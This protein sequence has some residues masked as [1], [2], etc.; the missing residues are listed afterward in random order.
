MEYLSYHAI[1]K[2]VKS[3]LEK[4][5]RDFQWLGG[6]LDRKSHLVNWDTMCTSKEKGGLGIRSL[7]KL[8]KSLLE[9]WN[10][11]LAVE[12]N[13]PWK[14]IIKL[15]Y[16]LEEGAWFSVEPK[17]SFVGLWKDIKREA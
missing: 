8:N 11:R 15:K 12:D 4:I 3:R 6:N 17:G 10:L 5:Q 9:K 13:P 16:R 7:V 2:G 1:K 14:D